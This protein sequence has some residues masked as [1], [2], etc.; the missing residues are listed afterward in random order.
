MP[1]F[2]DAAEAQIVEDHVTGADNRRSQDPVPALAN[3]AQQAVAAVVFPVGAPENDQKHRQI[4]DHHGPAAYGAGPAAQ[5]PSS[6]GSHG[7]VQRH[8]AQVKAEGLRKEP[9]CRS[10]GDEQIA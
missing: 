9:D 6:P 4:Q 8:D 1:E 3:G 5:A 7:K 2:Q 10:Q